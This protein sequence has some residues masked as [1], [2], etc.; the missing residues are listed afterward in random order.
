[1][2]LTS[3]VIGKEF[4]HSLSAED[5]A[6]I[7]QAALNSARLERTWTIEDAEK[8]ATD[9]EEQQRLGIADYREFPNSEADKLKSKVQ[10]VYE[11]YEQIFT[12]GLV[13]RILNA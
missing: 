4:W 3:I 9:V 1:M 12:P 2:Y 10:P 13:N 6:V 8:I 11:K 7:Q 5:Q